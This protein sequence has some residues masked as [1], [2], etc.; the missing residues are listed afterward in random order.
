MDKKKILAISCCTILVFSV[1]IVSPQLTHADFWGG[2]NDSLGGVFGNKKHKKVTKNKRGEAKVLANK[3]MYQIIDLECGYKK[4]KLYAER[5]GGHLAVIDSAYESKLLYEFMV[6]QGY[7]G[8][9]FGLID[10]DLNGKWVNT[11]GNYPEF[12]YWHNGQPKRENGDE[13]YAMLH[14][15]YKD[16]S[17]RSGAFTPVNKSKDGTA[18]IIEWDK[19]FEDKPVHVEEEVIPVQ[20]D[21]V[22]WEDI[23]DDEDVISG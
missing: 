10:E 13:R 22:Y 3:Q 11:Y 14:K 5:V 2:I 17:W 16:G 1:S 6:S 21:D 7:R 12:E 8:A 15:R 9:Y 4:A 23:Q 18:F 19:I 20:Q